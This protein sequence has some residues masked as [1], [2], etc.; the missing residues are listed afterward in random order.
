[1]KVRQVIGAW[2]SV[3]VQ[4]LTDTPGYKSV[5]LGFNSDAEG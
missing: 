2:E 4:W 3:M 5:G 1:M